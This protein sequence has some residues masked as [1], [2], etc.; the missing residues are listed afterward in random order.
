[1][2]RIDRHVC[3]NT[4]HPVRNT[5]Q[6]QLLVYLLSP[7]FNCLDGSEGLF[8][9]ARGTGMAG[10]GSCFCRVD[11]TSTT[12][13]SAPDD[14]IF[15]QGAPDLAMVRELWQPITLLYSFPINTNLIPPFP[16]TVSSFSFW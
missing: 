7:A 15:S 2:V 12:H 14:G 16:S 6:R 11:V 4:L 5:A 10:M 13:S 1:M 9:R 3:D 8:G